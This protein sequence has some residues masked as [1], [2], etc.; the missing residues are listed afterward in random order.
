M[1]QESAKVTVM[2]DMTVNSEVL[3]HLKDIYIYI[4]LFYRYTNES[5]IMIVNT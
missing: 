5:L 3:V 4:Y 1:H 2:A